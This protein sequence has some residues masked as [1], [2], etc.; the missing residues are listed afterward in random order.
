MV[1][2]TQINENPSYLCRSACQRHN[3]SNIL[4][5]SPR[6]SRIFDNFCV[7]LFLFR[8]FS[9]VSSLLFLLLYAVS[10]FPFFCLSFSLECVAWRVIVLA[11]NLKAQN[12]IEVEFDLSLDF[13]E[14]CCK[15][16]H[17][18]MH[19]KNNNTLVF[20]LS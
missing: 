4:T 17:F 14:F 8:D 15:K 19:T 1:G 12:K 5:F 7:K 3:S 10:F 20:K 11:L 2:S 9:H 6:I 16:T 13:F 18:L